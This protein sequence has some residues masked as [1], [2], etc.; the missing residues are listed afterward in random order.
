VL[1]GEISGPVLG[2]L[3]KEEKPSLRVILTTGYNRETVA[4][5]TSD[6]TLP[7]ILNKPY[8]PRTLL[9]AVHEVLA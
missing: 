5:K 9:K 4:A 1:P 7:F 3:L 2:E 6:G 8:T